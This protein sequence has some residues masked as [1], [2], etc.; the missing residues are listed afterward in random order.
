MTDG[1]VRK[2]SLTLEGHATS[3]S[4]EDAFWE[5]LQVLAA[6]NGETVPTLAARI[7]A[8]RGA[9]SLSSALRVHALETFRRD[10][11]AARAP[12]GSAKDVA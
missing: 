2:R 4:L 3:V 8:E 10:A 9:A 1:R 7:D 5:A 6:R 11:E 12:A